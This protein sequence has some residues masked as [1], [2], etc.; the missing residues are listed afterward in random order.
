MNIL[1]YA[2]LWNLN[3]TYLIMDEFLKFIAS[4]NLNAYHI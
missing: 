2:D 1:F 4:D 3:V